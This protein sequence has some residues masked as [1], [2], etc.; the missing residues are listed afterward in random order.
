MSWIGNLDIEA[1]AQ[2]INACGFVHDIE[3]E[4]VGARC[5]HGE[6]VIGALAFAGVFGPIAAAWVGD[7]FKGP[8]VGV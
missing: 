7:G 6:F 1:A 3:A 4:V 2:V 5:R 8:F